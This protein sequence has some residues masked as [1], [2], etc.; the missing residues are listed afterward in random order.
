MV[1]DYG[2][3]PFYFCSTLSKHLKFKYIESPN[4]TQHYVDINEEGTANVTETKNI[5]DPL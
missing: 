5:V 4:I 2:N 1:G 3:N